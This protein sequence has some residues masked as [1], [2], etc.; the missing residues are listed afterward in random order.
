M[1][2]VCVCVFGCVAACVMCVWVGMGCGLIEGEPF[3]FKIFLVP[4]NMC[5]SHVKTLGLSL[6]Q[7]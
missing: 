3:I 7:P 6:A 5:L 1:W 4:L 2:Y